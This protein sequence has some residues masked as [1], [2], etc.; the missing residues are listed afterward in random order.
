MSLVKCDECGK[1]VSDTAKACPHCG[2]A[3][4][5]KVGMLGIILVSLIGFAIFQGVL[6]SSS[7]PPPT[8]KT[9]AEKQREAQAEVAFQKVVIVLKSIKKSARNPDSIAWES[10]LADTDANTVCVEFRG[11]NGFGGMTKEFAVYANGALSQAPAAW[12]KHCA[13]K[14]FIDMAHARHAL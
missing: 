9:E 13:N 5:K 12:N 11:Q 7:A 8:P 6:S 10:I 4:K 14:K 2:T 1:D 3:V